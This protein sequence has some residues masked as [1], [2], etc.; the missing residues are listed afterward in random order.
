MRCAM[1]R[2]S[3]YL[4]TALVTFG[5]C[6]ASPTSDDP[7]GGGGKADGSTTT[8]T[9]ADDF[10]ESANGP[11]LGG[12]SIHIAYDLDRLTDCKASSGGKDTYGISGYAQFDDGAPT[13]FSV[14]KLDSGKLKPVVASLGVP[15]DAKKV[16]FWFETTNTTGCHAI[17]SNEGANY[18]FEVEATGSTS[19]VLSFDADFSESQS[20]AVHALD[21]VIVHY[22][23]TRLAQCANSSGGHA[24]WSVTGYWQVDG[25]AVHSLAVTQAN[26]SVLEASD[27]ALSVPRGTDL[28]LWFEATSAS[29]CHAYDSDFGANYHVEIQ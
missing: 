21:K 23:P 28:A 19:T 4:A 17:D 20:A 8:I 22:D 25:G 27:P 7:A 18:T 15:A 29:G 14:S 16:A 26:G 6:A 12:D 13:P 11:L 3:L 10:S 24:L 2:S 1:I 9:F 5:A